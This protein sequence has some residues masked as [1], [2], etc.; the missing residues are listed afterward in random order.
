MDKGN[1]TVVLNII[2][3]KITVD[4]EIPLGI[5]AN[6]LIIALNTAYKLGI[7]TTDI[8][9]CCIKAERPIAFIKGNRLLADFGVRNG[10]VLFI[11]E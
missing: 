3:R 11:T 7:D 6:E 9:K 2:K 1:V 5:S 8:K 4:I 10:S